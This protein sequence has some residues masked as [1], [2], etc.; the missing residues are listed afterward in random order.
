M[1]MPLPSSLALGMKFGIIKGVTAEMNK[2]ILI[3]AV[4]IC[5]I[6]MLFVGCG[7]NEQ[8]NQDNL[9]A[10]AMGSFSSND[11]AL[12]IEGKTYR[13]SE[14]VNTLLKVL[15]DNY[16]YSEAISCAYDGLDKSY[17][18]DNIDVYTYPDKDIDR[19]SEI[20]IY[21]GDAETGKGLKVGDTVKRMEELYGT[22]Y[23]EE[24]ITLIYEIPP[25]QANA[26]GAS[27]YVTVE[28]DIIKSIAIT[29]ELLME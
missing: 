15:G 5:M 23:S 21:G 2:R 8:N 3:V 6:A 27:L 26:E 9:P 17:S 19:V 7:E 22:G 12:I 14:N 25:K 1:Y 24:G 4:V 13:S 29:A 16:M 28:D 18:Y 11:I 10:A 20:T